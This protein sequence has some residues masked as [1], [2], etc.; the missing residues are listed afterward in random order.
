M[1]LRCAANLDPYKTG[2]VTKT[3]SKKPYVF[4]SSTIE[5]IAILSKNSLDLLSTHCLCPSVCPAA[6]II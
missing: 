3:K 1:A 6:E 4:M 5:R 2:T